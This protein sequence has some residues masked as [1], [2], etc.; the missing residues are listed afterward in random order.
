MRVAVA[1]PTSGLVVGCVLGVLWPVA[2]SAFLITLLIASAILAVGA[3]CAASR[4]LFA[5]VLTVCFAT[6]GALL[7][8]RQWQDDWRPTLKVAFESIA[9]DE[10]HELQASGRLVPE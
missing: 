10:R 6:G 3:F 8:V 4:V 9:R 7:A 1:L 5:S 2:P